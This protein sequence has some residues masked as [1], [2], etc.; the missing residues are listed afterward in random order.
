MTQCGFQQLSCPLVFEHPRWN[1]HEKSPLSNS[2]GAMKVRS[3][4][5]VSLLGNWQIYWPLFSGMEMWEGNVSPHFI[6]G[7]IDIMSHFTSTRNDVL[8]VVYTLLH[9][10]WPWFHCVQ[11]SHA[12]THITL[13]GNVVYV[14]ELRWQWKLLPVFKRMKLL[15]GKMKPQLFFYFGS[16]EEI[17]VGFSLWTWKT[18]TKIIRFFSIWEDGLIFLTSIIF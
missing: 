15:P 8:Y 6:H 11:I 9:C 18:M 14:S 16:N 1:M 4:I 3:L 7:I 12:R 13:A 10:K 5:L 2:V 17:P